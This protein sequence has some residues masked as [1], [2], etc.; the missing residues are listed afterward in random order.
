MLIFDP[1]SG[2]VYY[3]TP[4]AVRRAL[5]APVTIRPALRLSGDGGVGSAELVQTG[6]EDAALARVDTVMHVKWQVQGPAPSAQPA[7]PPPRLPVQACGLDAQR[8]RARR[9]YYAP[10]ALARR[11]AG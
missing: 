2:A 4:D 9:W 10:P 11:S 8:G 7:P 3:D 1:R 5:A 6:G